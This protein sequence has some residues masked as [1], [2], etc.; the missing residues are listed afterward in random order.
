VGLHQAIL[1]KIAG[2]FGQD[3]GPFWT[4]RALNRATQGRGPPPGHFGQEKR[5]NF[6]LIL[7]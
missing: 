4:N 3:R 5:F 6:G 7:V 2:H 1:D